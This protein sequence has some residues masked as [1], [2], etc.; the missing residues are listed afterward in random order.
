MKALLI[1]AESFFMNINKMFV[2]IR[3]G[4]KVLFFLL[5]F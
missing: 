3:K 1:T 2:G 4:A 5:I